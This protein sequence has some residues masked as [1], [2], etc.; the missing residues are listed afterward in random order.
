MIEEKLEEIERFLAQK[1]ITLQIKRQPPVDADTIIEAEK[2][3]GHPLPADLRQIYLGFADGFDVSWKYVRSPTDC[4]FG[5]FWL[6]NLE[7]F[8]R[9]VLDL[10]EETREYYENAG[11]Y[12]DRP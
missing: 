6:P 4:D 10:R 1:G 11:N 8:V 5:R 9:G 7:A 3:L 12:F 2:T